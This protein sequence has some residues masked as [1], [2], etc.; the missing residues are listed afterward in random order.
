LNGYHFDANGMRLET[1]WP[2]L[3]QLK[4]LRLENCILEGEDLTQILSRATTKLRS[5]SLFAV[6]RAFRNH[7]LPY[8]FADSLEELWIEK[9]TPHTHFESHLASYHTLHSLH[10]DW[11][12]FPNIVPFAP[13]SLL[14]I[15]IAIPSSA[16]RSAPGYVQFEES[17]LSLDLP[18]LKMIRIKG[19]RGDPLLNDEPQLRRNLSLKN[20]ELVI[21]LVHRGEG[22]LSSYGP[23]CQPLVLTKSNPSSPHF[24]IIY[25]IT[26]LGNHARNGI[27]NAR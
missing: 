15:T 21:E 11:Y 27:P 18:R 5:L 4:S 3:P 25:R 13:P 23:L 14:Y 26:Y 20:I 6:R 7:E 8:F 16:A 1:V 9:C 2:E 10:V 19:Q 17:L 24:F 22:E 12:D